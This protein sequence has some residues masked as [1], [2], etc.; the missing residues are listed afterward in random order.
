MGGGGCKSAQ[1]VPPDFLFPVRSGHSLVPHG[2]HKA[3]V[4]RPSFSLDGSRSVSRLHCSKA[5]FL[6]LPECQD[7]WQIQATGA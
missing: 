4:C 1:C 3:G 7:H 2:R 6:Y 5:T